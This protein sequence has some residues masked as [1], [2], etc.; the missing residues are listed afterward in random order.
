MPPDDPFGGFDPFSGSNNA[1]S[2]GGGGLSTGGSGFA[3]FSP[4]KVRKMLM[5]IDKKVVN[6]V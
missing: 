3:D 6:S 4:S 5:F 1:G 2:Q